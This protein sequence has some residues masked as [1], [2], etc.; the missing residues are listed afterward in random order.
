MKKSLSHSAANKYNECG[1]SYELHYIKRWRALEQSAAL[2]FGT[3]IDKALESFLLKKQLSP[4]EVFETLWKE[5]ELNGKPTKLHNETTIVYSN[6]DLDIELLDQSDYDII[7][8]THSVADVL[9]TI[10][11]IKGRKDQVGFKKLSENDKKIFNHMNWLCM[12]KKGHLMVEAGVQWI[13]ENVERV[14]ATQAKIELE[15]E[16]KDAVIGYADLIAKIKGHDK[17]IVIDF[18]TSGRM[19]E[20][21]SVITSPQLALYVFTLKN[22]YENTNL[23]GYVIFQKNIRKNKT[24]ICKSCGNDGSGGR[25]KTCANVVNGVR[26]NGEWDEKINPSVVIQVV[27]SEISEFFQEQV[28]D[29]YN[30][31]NLGIKN[32]VFPRNWSSCVRYNGTVICPYYNYCHHN[33]SDDIIK[34]EEA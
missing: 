22:K 11:D 2:L 27:V 8:K 18:K 34:K 33:K 10:E 31:I 24:K 16:D 7:N 20:Q 19:Y 3:A 25:H 21:D 1:K 32:N 13:T 30:S 14:Y 29:N 28:V 9:G 17:P 23:G 4:L 26:C 12:R 5:Q 6:N 15:N